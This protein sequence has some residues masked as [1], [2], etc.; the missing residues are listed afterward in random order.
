MNPGNGEI[1]VYAVEFADPAKA[2]ADETYLWLS[3]R[4][5]ELA[6]RWYGGLLR[7]AEKL[8]T[9]PTR[10]ALAPEQG[11][12]GGAEVR[13]LLYRCGRM[14]HRILFFLVDA[15]GDGKDDTIR[16]LHV[17]HAARRMLG[18]DPDEVEE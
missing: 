14:V 17:R 7:E 8:S 2:E 5:P 10:C 9:F 1:A 11:V 15:D 16:I 12:F 6:A 3:R 4:S 18:G 13:Q